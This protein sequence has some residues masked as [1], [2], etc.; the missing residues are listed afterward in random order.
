LGDFALNTVRLLAACAALF[1]PALATAQ[2]SATAS[3]TPAPAVSPAP[4]QVQTTP[5]AAA[6]PKPKP[7]RV[8]KAIEVTG[9]RLGKSRVCRTQDEWDAIARKNREATET[10]V[11]RALD[12]QSSSGN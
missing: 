4:E 12:G 8:C 2:E 11:R 3:P 7:L 1:T 5:V 9:S 10:Q 6:K